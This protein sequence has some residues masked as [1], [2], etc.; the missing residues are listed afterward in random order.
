MPSHDYC[1]LLNMRK[2]KC[3]NIVYHAVST[4]QAAVVATRLVLETGAQECVCLL[5]QPVPQDCSKH[6]SLQISTKLI[7]NCHLA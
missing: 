4:E 1:F 3:L 5:D 6:R 2:D 7:Y